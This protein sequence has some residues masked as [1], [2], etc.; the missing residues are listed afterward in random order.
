MIDKDVFKK[1]I[2]EN[3]LFCK[4]NCRQCVH[5]V[6]RG[7]EVLCSRKENESESVFVNMYN[8]DSNANCIFKKDISLP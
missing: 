4:V 5:V 1:V 6:L 7:H 3:I 8:T 2:H